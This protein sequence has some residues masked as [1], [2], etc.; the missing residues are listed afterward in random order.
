MTQQKQDRQPPP[1]DAVPLER[2]AFFFDFD[3]TLVDIV[4]DPAAVEVAPTTRAS[5]TALL[6]ATNSSV[7]VVSG[8]EIDVLDEHL[9]PLRLAAAGMHGAEWR[10]PDGGRHRVRVQADIRSLQEK[11]AAFASRNAGLVAEIKPATVA[12]HY[13]NK[14]E[15]AAQCL[16]FAEGL[17]REQP[18]L[19][20]QHGKMVVELIGTDSN[21]GDALRAFMEIPPF[22]GR[23]PLF[24]GDDLTDEHGFLA[25]R[26]WNGIGVKIGAGPSAADY[27]LP[28]ITAFHRWMR[29]LLPTTG[30]SER[31]QNCHPRS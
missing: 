24:V 9:A 29:S 30:T 11:V 14:P 6:A 22:A 2:T 15:M 5:L 25:L 16:R 18:H 26:E 7:A 28:D 21:K 23:I 12:L 20:L 19:R 31:E 27:R 3:G 10:T 1:P 4:E 17:V 8:R 13:R